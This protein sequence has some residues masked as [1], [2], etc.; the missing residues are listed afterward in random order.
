MTDYDGYLLPDKPDYDEIAFPHALVQVIPRD[1]GTSIAWY[2]YSTHPFVL[3]DDNERV[4][5]VGEVYYTSAL[6]GD[7]SWTGLTYK[8]DAW[9]LSLPV[10]TL[11]WSN[12]DIRSG[13]M[14]CNGHELPILPTY[15]Y[16]D[17]DL[18]YATIL[19][20]DLGIVDYFLFL[21]AQPMVYNT[22][23]EYPPSIFND[24]V[25]DCDW[26]R[27]SCYEHNTH[28]ETS[29]YASGGVVAGSKMDFGEYGEFIWCNYDME[30][31]DQEADARRYD[32]TLAY[33]MAQV[34]PHIAM[35]GEN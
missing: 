3:I 26:I 29:Y 18:P 10:D 4:T 20:R 27:Y 13:M 33:L 34:G 9:K 25:E 17:K 12:T 30:R 35:K 5:N 6:V 23:R 31:F 14:D 28:W 19:R 11:V 16:N 2:R 32:F 15:A 21:S 1:D 7:T 24:T 22:Y 8:D